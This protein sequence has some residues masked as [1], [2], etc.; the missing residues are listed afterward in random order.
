MTE[1]TTTGDALLDVASL[2]Q[3][4]TTPEKEETRI[5]EIG[6][7]IIPTVPEAEV[8]REI[9]ALKDILDKEQAAL[10]SE[11]FPKLRQLAYPMQKR[12]S[13]SADSFV[14]AGEGYHRYGSGYFGWV[15]FETSPE[16]AL[17]IERSLKGFPHLLRYLFI[18]TIRE[19]TL[20]AGRPRMDRRE[21]REPPKGTPASAPISEAELDRSLEKLIAE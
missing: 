9:T 17:R 6:Y 15:K 3:E 21:R 13:F 14:K 7:L 1:D 16:N 19:H 8:T 12:A 2:E 5:Y 4:E 10:I 20:T 18:K 11:E